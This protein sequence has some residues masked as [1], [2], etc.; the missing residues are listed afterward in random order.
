[1]PELRKAQ[2]LR[3]LYGQTPR[4]IHPGQNSALRSMS[5]RNAPR[6]AGNPTKGASRTNLGAEYLKPEKTK[7]S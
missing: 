7:E 2:D 5:V 3:R 1:M 4:R 6:I